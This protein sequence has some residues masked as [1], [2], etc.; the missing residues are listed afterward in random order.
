MSYDYSSLENVA[1]SQIVDKG[2]LVT[3]CYK[4][5]GVYNAQ[6]DTISGNSDTFSIVKAVVL[7]YNQS[8]VDGSIIRREDKQVLIAASGNTKPRT[9]DTV[10]DNSLLTIMNVVEV[11]TG[12]TAIIYKLQ[13]R[14][15]G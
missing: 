10:N 1:L 3:I 11:K 14:K 13:V 2:R 9:G 15:N 8:D 12:D 7:D 4:S 5:E 6:N